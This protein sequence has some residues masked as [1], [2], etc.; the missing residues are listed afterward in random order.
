MQN[1]ELV[2]FKEAMFVDLECLL[3]KHGMIVPGEI[4]ENT[5]LEQIAELCYNAGYMLD[6]RIEKPNERS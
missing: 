4:N 6:V 5:T 1:K 3:F 2:Y